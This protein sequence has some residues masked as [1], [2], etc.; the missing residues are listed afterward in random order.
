VIANG[1]PTNLRNKRRS[2]FVVVCKEVGDSEMIYNQVQY[3]NTA[4]QPNNLGSYYFHYFYYH[5]HYYQRGAEAAPCSLRSCS[6]RFV[7]W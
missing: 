3:N 6:A 7:I 2:W 1:Q 5:Y 4:Q